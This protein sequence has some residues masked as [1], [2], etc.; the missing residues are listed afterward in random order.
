MFDLPDHQQIIST[1]PV[2]QVVTKIL[3]ADDRTSPP[4]SDLKKI[5]DFFQANP[6]LSSCI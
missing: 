4:A 6:G 5:A 3:L 2:G 1:L